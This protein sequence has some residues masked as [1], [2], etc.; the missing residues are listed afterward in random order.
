MLCA[1]QNLPVT[2]DR[3]ACLL[4][5]GQ[6]RA[7]VSSVNELRIARKIAFGFVCFISLLVPSTALAAMPK[8]T[9]ATTVI[10]ASVP[11]PVDIDIGDDGVMYV[12]RDRSGSGG[13]TADAVKIHRIGPG[14]ST[15]EEFGNATIPDPDAVVIDRH[16]AVSGTPGAVLVGGQ[17]ALFGDSRGRLSSI[18][19]DGRVTI[20]ADRN[21]ILRNP[22]SFVFDQT[23]RLL[24]TTASASQRDANV[25]AISEGSMVTLFAKSG[26]SSVAADSQNNI[27]VSSAF[28]STLSLYAFDGSLINSSFASVKPSAPLALAKGGFWGTDIYSVGT[29]GELVRVSPN[30]DSLQVGSGFENVTAMVFGPDDALYLSE[31]T[32][33]RILRLRPTPP[34]PPNTPPVVTMTAPSNGMVFA[35][36][37]MVEISAEANDPDGSIAG[38]AFYADVF[39]LGSVGQT[40]YRVS[41]KNLAAG[42]YSVVAAATDNL[43][44]ITLSSPVTF[45]I[46]VPPPP[47]VA[48][49]VVVPTNMP[50]TLDLLADRVID[51]DAPPQTIVLSGIGPGSVNEIQSLTVT[52][53]S[54]NPLLIPNPLVSY[55]TPDSSGAIQFQS[56]PNAFGLVRISLLVQDNGGTNNGG[57]DSI[58]RSF[59]VVVRPVNDLPMVSDIRDQTT[60]AGTATAALPLTI[61]DVETPAALLQ[62]SAT[63]SNPSLVPTNNILFGGI[64]AN[65]TVTIGPFAGRSGAATI[66]VTVTDGDGGTASDSFVVTVPEIPNTPPTVSLI[67]PTNGAVFFGP[68]IILSALAADSDGVVRRVE[69]FQ[70]DTKLG[71]VSEAPY[72]FTWSNAPPGNQRLTAIATDDRGASSSSAPVFVLAREPESE[73]LPSCPPDLQLGFPL[74]VSTNAFK[75]GQAM[76]LSLILRQNGA[77]EAIGVTLTVTLPDG[78]RLVGGSSTN[79][80]EEGNAVTFRLG[81]LGQGSVTNVLLRVVPEIPGA[82]D[83]QFAVR[84]NGAEIEPLDNVRDI[85]FEVLPGDPVPRLRIGREGDQ[86]RIDLRAS[87]TQPFLLQYSTNLSTWITLPAIPQPAVSGVFFFDPIV[88]PSRAYRAISQ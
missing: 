35:P 40:P 50:P 73:I 36:G 42:S 17:L 83:F 3:T 79:Y 81:S 5:A 76:N 59:A 11:D 70:G 47:P 4:A 31:F 48:T 88:E 44:A 62:L 54:D 8:A 25:V 15:I 13:S 45:H 52:A 38:V 20:L 49:N 18:A 23:G 80:L 32:E 10:Y 87:P 21:P 72:N 75:A 55:S 58:T 37:T 78:V 12:G 7:M 69:F 41:W 63:S 65:R 84:S 51:E 19:P 24:M 2:F 34:P 68:S 86:A 22:D 33:D 16:G 46:G 82:L 1:P 60:P 43:G 57:Q 77:C 29:S 6:I 9:G 74:V 67:S 26:A 14:G 53:T 56:L 64:G 61:G 39:P 85:V 28:E 30:G 27:V 66:V 71:E